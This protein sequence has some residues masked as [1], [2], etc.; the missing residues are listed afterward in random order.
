[1]SREELV[2]AWGRGWARSRRVPAVI[3][4]P[5]GLLL[6][7]GRPGHRIRYLLHTWDEPYLRE[8]G[9]EI[10]TP[11]AWIKLDGSARDLRAALPPHWRMFESNQLMTAPLTAATVRAPRPFKVTVEADHAGVLTATARH[12]RTGDLASSGRLAPGG[13]WGVI[14]QVETTPE[15]RRRGL[16][17]VVI[18]ALSDHAARRGIRTGVLAAT[19]DGQALYRTLG[20][21]IATELAAAFIPEP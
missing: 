11:G 21:T 5:G 19:D 13:G 6:D 3:T 14:D 17:T 18:Q 2:V 8:L 9:H 12:D 15:Y 20:W 16:G 7:V 10:T 1:M 4:I